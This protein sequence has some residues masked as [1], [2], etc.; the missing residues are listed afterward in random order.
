MAATVDQPRGVHNVDVFMVRRSLRDVPI[1][2]PPK[3]FTLSAGGDCD[4]W[5][6]IQQSAEPFINV[7]AEGTHEGSWA[8]EFVP[9]NGCV[10]ADV[11]QDVAIGSMFTMTD[12]A[13]GEAVGT[14]TAFRTLW[15]P[16]S[17]GRKASA[18]VDP[19]TDGLVHWVALRPEFQ[20]RGLSKP[21]FSAVLRAHAEMG[22]E[23]A[24][25][26]TSTGRPL[27]IAL[28]LSF[29]FEPFIDGDEDGE[30]WRLLF[31]GSRGYLSSS[32]IGGR[33]D[34]RREKT[35]QL[36]VDRLRPFFSDDSPGK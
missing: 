24:T 36:I 4:A 30:G 3:G 23:T 27:A 35:H 7:S 9:G 29:G 13:T 8:H 5:V 16:E 26:H 12:T 6:S 10:P 11:P 33:N 14:A 28:Y 15:H 21:L 19:T 22:C 18:G 2:E 31:E 34:E 20:G 32:P 17:C 1:Y 25:L